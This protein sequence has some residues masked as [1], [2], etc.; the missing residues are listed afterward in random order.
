M[1]GD[2]VVW[3]CVRRWLIWLSPVCL[4]LCNCAPPTA[5]L[6]KDAAVERAD[7]EQANHPQTQRERHLATR[8]KAVIRCLETAR[9]S[10]VAAEVAGA[11]VEAVRA[12]PARAGVASARKRRCG[13]RR[14][15][16]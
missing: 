12:P 16:C 9:Q 15:R 10:V 4:L 7:A 13:K 2:A 14:R 8:V 1:R 6:P 11:G 3:S 5:P